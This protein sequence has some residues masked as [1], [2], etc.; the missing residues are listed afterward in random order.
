MT[1]IYLPLSASGLRSLS[2]HGA[3]EP[4][5]LPA[6][7]VTQAMRAA[8]L[9]K[10]KVDSTGTTMRMK[11]S[12]ASETGDWGSYADWLLAWTDRIR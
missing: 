5:P 10:A 1:R 2:T 9:P 12:E 7:A 4:A 6:H 11:R 8:N 3:V